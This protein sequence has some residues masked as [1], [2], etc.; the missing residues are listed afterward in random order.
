MEVMG[1]GYK[2][3][4]EVR[5]VIKI[6]SLIQDQGR[7]K[8]QIQLQVLE[9]VVPGRLMVPGSEIKT[10]KGGTSLGEVAGGWND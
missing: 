3:G 4:K 9:S 10:T 1:N 2:K 8:S 5:E 6:T 7:G